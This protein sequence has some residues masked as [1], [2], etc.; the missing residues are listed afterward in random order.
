MNLIIEIL[1][2]EK[3]NN[4]RNGLYG[5]TQ[6]SLAYNSNKIEG[7]TLTEEDTLTLFNNGK[8]YNKDTV[9]IAKHIEEMTGHFAMFNYM[10]D[11]IEKELNH[12]LIKEL[13][14]LL[15]QGVFEDLA[16]G[17]ICGDYKKRPNVVGKDNMETSKPEEVK[18]KMT[19]LLSWYNNISKK[20]INTMAIFHEKYE[21][22]HPFQDGNGRTGRIILF[23]ECLKNNIIPPILQD[24]NKIEYYRALEEAHNGNINLLKNYIIKEQ[25]N[26]KQNLIKFSIDPNNINNTQKITNKI[27]KS[28]LP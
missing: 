1:K 19:E 13:H 24:K 25:E 9:Y 20:D 28:I 4:I 15:K 16:N 21:K 5:L 8:L 27:K 2:Q 26:Y 18:E 22:I 17:F 11:N 10:L 7:S 14:K 3:N 6:R 12:D 23:K